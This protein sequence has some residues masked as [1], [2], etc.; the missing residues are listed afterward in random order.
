MHISCTLSSAYSFL[1]TL[2]ISALLPCSLIDVNWGTSSGISC[3]HPA[4]VIKTAGHPSNKPQMCTLTHN[5]KL[6]MLCGCRV[7]HT[8]AGQ[9]V[10]LPELPAISSQAVLVPAIPSRAVPASVIPSHA[11]PATAKTE[12]AKTDV[13]SLIAH[14]QPDGLASTT[15]HVEPEDTR[16]AF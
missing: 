14:A 10:D 12:L 6:I 7:Q 13:P 5:Q 4:N 11:V 15:Q 3:F 8:T 9:P 16:C 1:G 2:C